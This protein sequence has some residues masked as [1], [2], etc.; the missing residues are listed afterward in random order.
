MKIWGQSVS[1]RGH[2]TGKGL[3][4]GTSLGSR[5]SRKAGWGLGSQRT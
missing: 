1:G 5:N 2:G 3:E 4:L